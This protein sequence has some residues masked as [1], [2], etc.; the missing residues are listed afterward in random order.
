MTA[1][2]I[3]RLEEEGLE[4][5]EYPGEI[6]EEGHIGGEEYF[7]EYGIVER[8]EVFSRYHNSTVGHYGVERTLKAMSL[9]GHVWDGMRR[10]VSKWISECSICQKIKF[11]RLPEWEGEV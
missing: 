8:H 11:Q 9:R 4:Q 2:L 6:E 3:F 7:E 1:E 5:T 10:N